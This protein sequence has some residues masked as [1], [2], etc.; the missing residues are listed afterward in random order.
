MR[1]RM[2]KE[3]EVYCNNLE[4]EIIYLKDYLEKPNNQL[5]NYERKE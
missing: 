4:V 1:I 2:L 3:K 5:M